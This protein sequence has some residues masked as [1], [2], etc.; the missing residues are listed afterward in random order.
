MLWEKGMYKFQQIRD[1]NY[2]YLICLGISPFDAHCWIFEKKY[3]IRN[4]TPQHKSATGVDYWIAVY[5]NKVND[6]AEKCGGTLDQAY[7]ILKNLK[8]K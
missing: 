3:A 2:D 4:A 5:P 7:Q 6:W 1:Q 8:K